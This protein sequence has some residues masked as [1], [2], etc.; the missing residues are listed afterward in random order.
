MFVGDQ[1]IGCTD[2]SGLFGKST[3]VYDQR[4]PILLDAHT[5][6][7]KLCEIHNDLL[8]PSRPYPFPRVISAGRMRRCKNAFME[9]QCRY[10]RSCS[11]PAKH[12][13]QSRENSPGYLKASN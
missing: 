3:G 12:F 8:D 10:S 5:G 6:V 13:Y 9:P 4:S 11:I 1:D 7:S 2:Y